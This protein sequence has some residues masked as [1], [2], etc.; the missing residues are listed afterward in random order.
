MAQAAHSDDSSPRIAYTSRAPASK[1]PLPKR[2]KPA[3]PPKLHRLF[4]YLGALVLGSMALWFLFYFEGLLTP[5]LASAICLLAAISVVLAVLPG[6]LEVAFRMRQ[7]T[8]LHPSTERFMAEFSDHLNETRSAVLY[9]QEKSDRLEKEINDSQ[10]DPDLDEVITSLWLKI[11]PLERLMEGNLGSLL[12][13]AETEEEAKEHGFP[14]PDGGFLNKAL[15]A[16]HPPKPGTAI[17]RIVEN[18]NQQTPD[19]AEDS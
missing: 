7:I 8:P 18:G 19:P 3:Q 12:R 17:R 2:F 5:L 1:K 10:P 6:Y 16:A 14:I 11:D 13:S 9:L 4:S 15:S